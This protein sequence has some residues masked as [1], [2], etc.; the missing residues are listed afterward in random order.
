MP[1]GSLITNSPAF[2]FVHELDAVQR[3]GL[4]LDEPL[5]QQG[6]S[7]DPA[8]PCNEGEGAKGHVRNSWFDQFPLIAWAVCEKKIN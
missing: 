7:R 8:D 1:Y 5:G 2:V 6:L 4:G 3:S